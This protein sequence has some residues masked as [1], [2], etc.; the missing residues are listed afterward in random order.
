MT[1][2]WPRRFPPGPAL[3]LEA[4]DSP[5]TRKQVA[6]SFLDGITLAAVA[7]AGLCLWAGTA[8]AWP[9][10]PP[11]TDSCAKIPGEDSCDGG[12]EASAP[13]VCKG[14]LGSSSAFVC[15]CGKK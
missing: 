2:A 8:S 9:I 3:R 7:I 13:N 1:G 10:Q 14:G 12:C 4:E 15:V 5:M 11:V 6:Q